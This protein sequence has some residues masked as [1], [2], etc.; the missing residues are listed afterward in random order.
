MLAALARADAAEH[1]ALGLP[2]T[3][4]GA[5]NGKLDPVLVT[6]TTNQQGN[7]VIV[8]GITRVGSMKGMFFVTTQP[9]GTLVVFESGQTSGQHQYKGPAGSGSPRTDGVTIKTDAVEQGVTLPHTIHIEGD[10]KC[11]S[12][13]K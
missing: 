7:F 6:C 11:G 5:V 1:G 3:A 12:N 2:D 4:D 9:D 8:R 10:A 13:G